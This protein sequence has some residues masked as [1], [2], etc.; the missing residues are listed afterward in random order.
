[1]D[2]LPIR[3]AGEVF[4]FIASKLPLT[5]APNPYPRYDSFLTA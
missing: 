2:T 5:S 1:M 3:A 4:D